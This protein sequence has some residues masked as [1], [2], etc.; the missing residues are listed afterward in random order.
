[1][2]MRRRRRVD[3]PRVNDAVRRR[4]PVFGVGRG[5]FFGGAQGFPRVRRWSGFVAAPFGSLTW[6]I[7]GQAGDV[8]GVSAAGGEVVVVVVQS[9][10]MQRRSSREARAL[11]VGSAAG[12]PRVR[13]GEARS[14][15]EATRGAWSP[16]VEHAEVLARGGD[17]VGWPGRDA[18]EMG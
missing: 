11:D 10:G 16:F 5:W 6:Q 15:V 13:M 4:L 2:A 12:T 14:P 3:P 18:A 7:G 17:A 8:E 9:D 1:M